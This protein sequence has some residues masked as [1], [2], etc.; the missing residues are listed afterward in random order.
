MEP[1]G[2]ITGKIT[3]FVYNCYSCITMD[4]KTY[5]GFAMFSSSIPFK[6]HQLST[7]C[8]AQLT[9][10]GFVPLSLD[11][12][13]KRKLKTAFNIIISK[14]TASDENMYHCCLIWCSYCWCLRTFMTQHLAHKTS[15]SQS[16]NR[17]LGLSWVDNIFVVSFITDHKKSLWK[18]RPS[19]VGP[20]MFMTFLGP[21]LQFVTWW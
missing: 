4:I 16:I 6:N 20:L 14:R 19:L 1:N 17:L 13:S 15:Y 3:N 9:Y 5:L 12:L 18:D 21:L 11:P 7:Y 10:L 2:S 8:R